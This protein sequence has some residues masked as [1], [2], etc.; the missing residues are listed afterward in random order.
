[1]Q[2]R[3]HS[4]VEERAGKRMGSLGGLLVVMFSPIKIGQFQCPSPTEL[5][6]FH[7]PLVGA[8]LLGGVHG[9]LLGNSH[10]ATLGIPAPRTVT[11]ITRLSVRSFRPGQPLFPQNKQQWATIPA[12]HRRMRR[13]PFASM[14]RATRPR[15]PAAGTVAGRESRPAA[16]L[17]LR[18]PKHSRG[19]R[20]L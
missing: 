4:C 18:Q 20:S 2:S 11:E 13:F 5:I 12:S 14:P 8:L 9:F 7:C 10:T 19:C 3:S 16:G 15:P 17:A 6:Q 1:M